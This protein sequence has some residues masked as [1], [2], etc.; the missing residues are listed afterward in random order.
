MC[1]CYGL[2]LRVGAALCY[3]AEPRGGEGGGWTLPAW[4]ARQALGNVCWWRRAAAAA[5]LVA[6]VAC[7]GRLGL[8]RDLLRRLRRCAEADARQ[9]RGARAATLP[10]ASVVAPRWWWRKHNPPATSTDCA[11]LESGV[12]LAGEVYSY[13]ALAKRRA[14]SHVREEEEEERRP[15]D[16]CTSKELVTALSPPPSSPHTRAVRPVNTIQQDSSTAPPCLRPR[17]RLPRRMPTRP[18]TS[19]FRLLWLGAG[20]DQ[21]SHAAESELLSIDLTPLQH[22]DMNEEMVAECTE[23]AQT[24]VEKHSKS[25]EVWSRGGGSDVPTKGG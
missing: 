12:F 23:S 11:D 16:C 17:P 19:T 14:V 10:M 21:R 5:V 24:A 1:T 8:H 2:H 4:P 15:P 22:T 7:G 13:E 6:A 25:N 3:A 9:E 20:G 18:R